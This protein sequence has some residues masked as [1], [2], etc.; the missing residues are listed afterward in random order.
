MIVFDDADLALAT[1]TII[2]AGYF[3]AGQD[4]TAATRVVAAPDDLRLSGSV[5]RRRRQG[6]DR[7]RPGRRGTPTS[8]L[9]T[10]STNSNVLPGSWNRTRSHAEVLTGGQ[11]SVDR[12]YCYRADGRRRAASRTTRS[13]SKEVFGP[14]ITVQRFTDEAEALEW[15]NGVDYGLASSVWTRDH[16]RAMRMST[17]PR[18][19]VRLDQHSRTLRR[20]DAARRLQE[21]RL[22][23]GPFCLRLRGLHTNKARNEQHRSPEPSQVRAPVGGRTVE[24]K[25]NAQMAMV[26]P[27]RLSTRRE[28]SREGSQIGG[29]RTHLEHRHGGGVDRACLQPGCDARVHRGEGEPAVAAG[30]ADSHSCRCFSS[31]SV[32]AR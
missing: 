7:G 13:S 23:Q 12:G 11:R 30:R 8:G 25:G 19:R 14:V 2:G 18:L 27:L 10:T 29:A 17:A 1:E 3:N 22:W 15:A 31:R 6:H 16:G 28:G 26:R 9:S 24:R 32:T 5:A 4:C 21:V 20:R